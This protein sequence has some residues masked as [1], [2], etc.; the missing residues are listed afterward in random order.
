VL[1]QEDLEDSPSLALE[2]DTLAAWVY[3]SALHDAAQET[4]LP[5][6]TFPEACPRPLEPVLHEDFWPGGNHP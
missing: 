1:V 5:L 4:G 2:L 6:A 3:P